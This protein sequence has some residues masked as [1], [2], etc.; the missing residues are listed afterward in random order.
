MAFFMFVDEVA[1]AEGCGWARNVCVVSLVVSRRDNIAFIMRQL[2]ESSQ[3]AVACQRCLFAERPAELR[4]SML[5]HPS[6]FF[7]VLL[8]ASPPLIGFVVDSKS[9]SPWKRRR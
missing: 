6:W 3:G 5:Q 7:N 1:C 4:K 2:V 8:T 9:M